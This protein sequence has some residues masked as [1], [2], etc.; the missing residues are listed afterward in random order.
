MNTTVYIIRHSENTPLANLKFI[1]CK[2]SNQL[3]NEKSILSVS[4]EKRAEELS[5]N[6]ELHNLDAI[7]SSSYAR[8]IAT[9]KYLALENNTVINID[10]RLNERKVGEI[11]DLDFGEFER[12]QKNDFDF[13]LSGGES[14]NLTKKEWLKL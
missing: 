5:K 9:A 2:D 4:G 7:Y 11:G 3:V 10:D 13:K 14:L 6:E 8:S 12:L 1:N